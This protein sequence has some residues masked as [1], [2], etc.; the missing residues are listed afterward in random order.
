MRSIRV[1]S[2]TIIIGGI[3]VSRT[4]YYAN[5]NER[6]N[7]SVFAESVHFFSKLDFRSSSNAV[8]ASRN[9]FLVVYVLPFNR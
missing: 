9:F 2:L 1:V 5:T 7:H 4:C 3:R 8:I 6:V